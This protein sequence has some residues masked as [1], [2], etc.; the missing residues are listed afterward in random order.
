MTT[1]PSGFSRPSRQNW[2]VFIG[3]FGH[4]APTDAPRDLASGPPD[5]V[6]VEVSV[7]ADG[8]DPMYTEHLSLL[9]WIRSVEGV[10]EIAQLSVMPGSAH[11]PGGLVTTDLRDIPLLD[12][13]REILAKLRTGEPPSGWEGSPF[14]PTQPPKGWATNLAKRPGAA[15]K[16]DLHYA[17][18]A[19]AYVHLLDQP[20]PVVLLAKKVKLKPSQVRSI[21]YEARRR[22]LLTDPPVKGRPGG[23]LT[24]KAREILRQHDQGPER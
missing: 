12:I 24:P 1:K 17:R 16:S 18:V 7:S 5:S 13:S 14:A 11:D 6:L 10:I 9:V 8:D 3:D 23:E 21:L 22:D 15:G 20:K 19:A 2:A 4:Q